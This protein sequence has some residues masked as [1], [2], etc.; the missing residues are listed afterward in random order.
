MSWLGFCYCPIKK[1]YHVDRHE[2]PDTVKYCKKYVNDNLKLKLW[3]FRWIQLTLQEV[4]KLEK[5]NSS[6][7]RDKAYVYKD[8][9]IGIA[10]YEFHVDDVDNDH[11]IMN[12]APYGRNQSVM[13]KENEKP[14]I[15]IGRDNVFLSII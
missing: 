6:F 12:G 7:V 11:E 9:T 5:E 13:G 1:S 10:M 4:E 15:I 8:E 14:I 3:C 2:Q